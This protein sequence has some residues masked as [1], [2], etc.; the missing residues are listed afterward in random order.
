MRAAPRASPLSAVP[1]ARAPQAPHAGVTVPWPP[2]RAP[3]ASPPRA[4]ARPAPPPAAAP[5]PP[6]AAPPPRPAAPPPRPAPPKPAASYDPFNPPQYVPAGGFAK[7]GG[8]LRVREA[9]RLQTVDGAW[10]GGLMACLDTGNEVRGAAAAQVGSAAARRAFCAPRP[11]QWRRT[12]RAAS[13]RRGLARPP[14]APPTALDPPSCARRARRR[15]P[16]R[17]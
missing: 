7:L 3:A 2:A 9:A 16:S 15:V 6:R 13:R 12:P 8:E 11:S 17:R 5:P 10:L 14:R 1:R 4:A